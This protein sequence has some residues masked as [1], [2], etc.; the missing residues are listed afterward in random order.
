[1]N[2]ELRNVVNQYMAEHTTCEHSFISFDQAAR[3]F[4]RA[5]C[6]SVFSG[7]EVPEVDHENIN[8]SNL[9]PKDRH[10]YSRYDQ[11]CPYS[12][13]SSKDSIT[14]SELGEDLNTN[15]W[16]QQD[17]PFTGYTPYKKHKQDNE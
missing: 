5:D 15:C 12:S 10:R 6:N 17:L 1:M 2:D 9:V 3:C 14:F 7:D 4:V 11:D 8:P 13:K 16:K